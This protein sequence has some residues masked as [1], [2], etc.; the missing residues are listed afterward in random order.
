LR[1]VKDFFQTAFKIENE[2]SGKDDHE[3]TEDEDSRLK[4]GDPDKVLLTCVGVGYSNINK[5]LL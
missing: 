3:D 1:H 4:I 5:T 2:H